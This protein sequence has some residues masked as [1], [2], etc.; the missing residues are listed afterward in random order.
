MTTQG[1]RQHTGGCVAHSR[2]TTAAL[3]GRLSSSQARVHT[4]SQSFACVGHGSA[5]PGLDIRRPLRRSHQLKLPTAACVWSIPSAPVEPMCTTEG[6]VVEPRL[7]HPQAVST[8]TRN[9]V[10]MSF[11]PWRGFLCREWRTTICSG[12]CYRACCTGQWPPLLV[13]GAPLPCER[14]GQCSFRISLSCLQPCCA[15]VSAFAFAQLT[16]SSR[17]HPGPPPTP[18]PPP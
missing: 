11:H 10:M 8:P 4:C 13:G 1:I 5:G 6:R 3:A 2:A 14:S 7:E 9:H 16:A 15:F 12:S 18:P 17:S